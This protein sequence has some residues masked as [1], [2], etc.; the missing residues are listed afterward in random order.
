MADTPLPP[1]V[2]LVDDDPMVRKSVA[3][4]LRSSG[5]QVETFSRPAVFLAYVASHAVPVAVLD[6]WM[7]SMTGMELLAHLCACS[8]LTRTIFI[9]GHED[10]AAESVVKAAGAFAFLLKPLDAEQFLGAVHRAFTT[11]RPTADAAR[12]N[13]P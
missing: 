5:F 11:P 2:C 10:P 8:P 7:E 12:A 13:G 6:I 4:L 3:R 9:T 1:V